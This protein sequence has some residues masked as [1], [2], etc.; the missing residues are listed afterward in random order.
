M[1]HMGAGIKEVDFEI[2]VEGPSK[3]AIPFRSRIYL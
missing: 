3:A 2:N 1:A